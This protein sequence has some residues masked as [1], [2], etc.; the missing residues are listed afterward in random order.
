RLT[1]SHVGAVALGAH[2]DMR[3]A[4]EHRADLHR[5]ASGLLQ[6][7]HNSSRALGR[8]HMVSLDH[9]LTGIRICNSLRNIAA[10]TSLLQVL[11]H[12]I[13]IH[14]GLDLHVG[15]LLALAAV[16]LTDNKILGYVHQTSG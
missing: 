12:F 8:T 14:E 6:H 3:L 2:T 9:N 11:N 1:C 15:D 13:S 10:G 5:L 7:L 16:H 4:A